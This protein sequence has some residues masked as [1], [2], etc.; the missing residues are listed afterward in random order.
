MT[1]HDPTSAPPPAADTG[2]LSVADVQ[3]RLAGR[4][5]PEYWRSLEELAATPEF[6]ELLHREF[7]RQASELP[8]GVDRRRFL[9]LMGASLALGG[10]TAC[11]RQPLESI[12]PYVEQPE[13]LVPG[14]P[15]YFATSLVQ[16][17]YATGLL[18]ESHMG[19]PTKLEGNPDHPASLGATD[20]FAQA[21]VLT[22]YDPERSQTVTHL[23][24]I[25]TWQAFLADARKA[26]AALAAGPA[27]ARIRVLTPPVS[28][29]S[30]TAAIGRLLERY[31][32]ARWHQWEPA[33]R[34]AARE[35]SRAAFGEPL[36]AR[37][38]L[39]RARVVV[40]LD[41][42]FL[43]AGPGAL[44]YAR[45]FADRRRVR[46]GSDSMSRFYAAESSPT[47]TGTMADHRLPVTARTL[48][49]LAVAL[50]AEV[51]VAGADAGGALGAREI[52]WARAAADALRRHRGQG[53][54]V[55]GDCAPAA[56]HT[57]VHAINQQLGNVG[58]TVDY[59]APVA[60]GEAPMAESF[61][62]L[63]TA[64]RAGEVDLLLALG[65]NP[66]YD[67]PADAGI[68]EALYQVPRRVHL[69]LYRDETAEFSQ[70][71]V[72]AAHYLE[73]WG[74]ARA[75]DGTVSLQQ[76]LIE[77]LYGGKSALELVAALA[78]DQER[79][80]REL[81][82]DGCRALAPADGPFEPFWRRCLHDGVIAGTAFEPRSAVLDAAAATAAATALAAE[83]ATDLELLFRPDPTVWDGS[84]ANNAW[85]QE[86]PKPLTKLTWDNALLVS[87]ALAARLGLASEDEVTLTVDGRSLEAPVWVQPGHPDG[88]VTLHLG[89]GRKAAGRVGTGTGVNAHLLRT[90]ATPW[91]AAGATIT[92]TGRRRPLASTQMH[93]NLGPDPIQGSNLEGREAERRHLVRVGTL[94]EFLHEPD[95][96]HHAEHGP[97]D[98][99]LHP[100]WEYD[101]HA[102]GLAVDLAACTGCNACVLACQA[103]NNIPVVGKQ[104]VAAGREM[105]WI[106][107]DRYY[108]GELEDPTVHHQPVMC[109]HC[110]QAPCEVVCPVAATVHSD[111]GLNDMVYNRCVG[112]RY[113]SNNCPYKVR[114][115][116]FF[117]YNDTDTPVLKLLRN[118]D[119][120]VR[121]RGVMEKCTYCVQRI[122]Y[123]RGE[124]KREQRSI[125]DG[126]I[127]T[128]C[129][130]VCPSRAIVF[131][132]I[133][134]PQSEVSR[135]KDEPTN[136]ALL[137]ELGTRPRTS[138]LAKITNPDPELEDEA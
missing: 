90:A 20:L 68:L 45:Q 82:R 7:P 131:G 46:R 69:G 78:D 96:V 63:L 115:F 38:D 59:T 94:E 119:V 1:V 17:G 81:V 113:C 76:P 103:E 49:L 2:R 8:A 52:A 11:T 105:H 47:A 125:R 73:S 54:V 100:D 114:R 136:Y 50:A 88:A 86:C 91:R 120:T 32:A 108:Q 26:L 57:L 130:Q 111:E 127:R 10:L 84:W 70:W 118:P 101:G 87:P 43:T 31:P 33:H 98:L 25:S 21:S 67:A 129:Q 29:P 58:R 112:T 41:T 13:S 34:D 126:E 116:N 35:G 62:E 75:F 23:G 30:L 60:G 85:L 117:K 28:S 48:G 92:A 110:E 51:G 27:G 53:L 6:E 80:D 104:Q 138:Y 124:A 19:R 44:R 3:R 107:V 5:G 122:N 18:A 39:A 95:F 56:V 109:M 16:G 9:Q 89:Y 72:P 37:Y 77:P 123:A 106:R 93:H 66:V 14:K 71:H 61:E 55:A 133:N 24:R 137:S 83:P 40:G 65:V 132:D 79:D 134:D 128:A 42:D 64:M 15:L 36:E 135:W 12:V 97:G 102:W 74:D 99:S 22:L 121:T 4:R